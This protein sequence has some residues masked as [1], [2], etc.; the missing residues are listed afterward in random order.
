MVLLGWLHL[1]CQRWA[2][3]S[4][5]LTIVRGT[6]Y[7]KVPKRAHPC[8]QGTENCHCTT[9]GIIIGC[10][11]FGFLAGHSP[12]PGFR[13]DTF[14]AKW[15]SVLWCDVSIWPGRSSP[16]MQLAIPSSVCISHIVSKTCQQVVKM[17]SK[18]VKVF[19]TF[20]FLLSCFRRSDGS[21]LFP[22]FPKSFRSRKLARNIIVYEC[23]PF[24]FPF[25]FHQVYMAL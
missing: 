9:I 13:V 19:H 5:L 15:L 22:A 16:R 18:V 23:C 10:D 2:I 20:L 4:L 24:L 8:S 25:D 6:M 7:P 12:A 21:F 14:C 3:K 17:S 11:D 1:K